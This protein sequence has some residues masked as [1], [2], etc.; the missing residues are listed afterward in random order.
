M[1]SRDLV[2]KLP[3]YMLVGI[4]EY[5][6]RLVQLMNV[7][8]FVVYVLARHSFLLHIMPLLNRSLQ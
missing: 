3:C 5:S 7:E 4:G 8:M 1:R 6:R 2:V